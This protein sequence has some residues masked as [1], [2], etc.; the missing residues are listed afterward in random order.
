MTP[1]DLAVSAACALV[2]FLCL[3][4]FIG[5]TIAPVTVDCPRIDDT[6]GEAGDGP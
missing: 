1:T 6:Q 4:L 5:C 3:R 2:L